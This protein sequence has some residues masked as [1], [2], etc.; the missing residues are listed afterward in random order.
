MECT[1]SLIF[2]LGGSAVSLGEKKKNSRHLFSFSDSQALNSGFIKGV[3][4]ELF[5]LQMRV[6]QYF[7]ICLFYMDYIVSAE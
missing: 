2:R 5:H 3:C 7:I 6:Y 4:S 1:S